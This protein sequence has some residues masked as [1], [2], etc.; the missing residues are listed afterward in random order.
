[1][2]YS[3][4]PEKGYIN[5]PDCNTPC[6]IEFSLSIPLPDDMWSGNKTST[7]HLIK[8]DKAK[9]ITR[10]REDEMASVKADYARKRKDI[11]R[12]RFK[13][14]RDTIYEQTFKHLN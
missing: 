11:E 9:G 4:Y 12:K 13:K 7:R 6:D 14:T 10:Y 3:K 1:M 2:Y 5:C 8:Q